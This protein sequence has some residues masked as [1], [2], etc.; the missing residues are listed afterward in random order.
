MKTFGLKKLPLLVQ[1]PKPII[2]WPCYFLGA[3]LQNISHVQ[4]FSNPPGHEISCMS[5][6]RLLAIMTRNVDSFRLSNQ[7]TYET[8]ASVI[9]SFEGYM[10]LSLLSEDRYEENLVL[11]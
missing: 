9:S 7:E 8:R 1:Q 4:R 3:G 5:Q 6:T 2:L 11:R 10:N